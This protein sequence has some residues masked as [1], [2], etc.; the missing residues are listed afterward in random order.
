MLRFRE[1]W[2]IIGATGMLGTDLVNSIEQLG[3]EIVGLDSSRL[4]IRSRD[5][6]M[7]VMQRFKPGIVFNTAGI[8]DVDG[9]ES[10]VDDAFD[11]NAHGPANV[12]AACRAV[13]AFLIHMSTDYVFDGRKGAP[14]TES[15][16]VN[17]LGIYGKSKAE[18]ERLVRE[19]L[20]D[21]HCIMRTQWLFGLH[22]RNFVEAIL[23]RASV[24]DTLTVVDDQYG[25][26][27]STVDLSHA[28][29]DLCEIGAQ[30]TIHVTNTGVTTWHAFARRIIALAGISGVRID[31][32]TTE[33]LGR[34]SPRPLYAVLDNSRFVELV[35]SPLRLWDDALKEYFA[36]RPRLKPSPRPKSKQAP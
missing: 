8:T 36:R 26:P 6:V 23:E 1:P 29:I 10:S 35:G 19:I 2:L 24:T 14:Y 32:M 17:P 13:G 7:E 27:T 21:D 34:A 9:C 20:P 5:S 3:P 28:M 25:C 30:G 15:D 11:V 22:G 16:P 18:G 33:E 31:A 12:A 4:D